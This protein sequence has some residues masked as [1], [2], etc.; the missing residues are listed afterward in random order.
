MYEI[1]H[2]FFF[3]KNGAIQDSTNNNDNIKEHVALF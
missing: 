1:Y 2:M 3:E